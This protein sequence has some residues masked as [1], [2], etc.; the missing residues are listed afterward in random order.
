MPKSTVDILNR[1]DGPRCCPLC[2]RPFSSHTLFDLK[3]CEARILDEP[4]RQR[5]IKRLLQWSGEEA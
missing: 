1:L 3:S 4:E 2:G 5:I